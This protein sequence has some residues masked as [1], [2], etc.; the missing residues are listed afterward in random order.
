M[1]VVSEVDAAELSNAVDQAKREVDNRYDFKGTATEIKLDGTAVQVSTASSAKLEA[2]FSVLNNK[3]A[4]RGLPLANVQMG[5]IEGASGTR[6]RQ[7][8]TLVEG[9]DKDRA[10]KIVK[11]IKDMKLKVQASIQGES[12]RVTGK[13]R[14]DLQ[15]VMAVLKEARFG[16]ELQFTN[17]RD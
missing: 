5:K 10:K 16:V 15:D 4:K 14:D 8:A 1:D 13:K 6:V 7:T 11:A 17:F 9:V 2:V 12:V 3:M